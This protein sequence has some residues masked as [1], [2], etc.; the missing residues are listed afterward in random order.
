MEGLGKVSRAKSEAEGVT[1]PFQEEVPYQAECQSGLGNLQIL[2]DAQMAMLFPQL[3]LSFKD[4][5]RNP[6]TTH[7]HTD[8]T[9]FCLFFLSRAQFNNTTKGLRD[10]QKVVQSKGE[11]LS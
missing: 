1:N 10:I 11:K 8:C 7:L 5:A 2:A 3:V 6:Q 4:E 9:T